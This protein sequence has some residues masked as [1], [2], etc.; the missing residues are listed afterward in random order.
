VDISLLVV[1]A[2]CVGLACGVAAALIA[3]RKNR[4]AGIY[5]V[6]GLLLGAIGILIA[7]VAKPGAPPGTRAVRCP[8]CNAN[9][10]IPEVDSEFECWQCHLLSRD[11]VIKGV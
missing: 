10:N 5:F 6:L 3:D 7:A 11:A 8:R 4:S 1:L 2:L 9:Q